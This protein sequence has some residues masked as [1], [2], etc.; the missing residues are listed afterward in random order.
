M[1]WPSAVLLFLAA[2]V[3]L[4]A[5]PGAAAY[6]PAAVAIAASNATSVALLDDGTV[7]QWGYSGAGTYSATPR[8]VAIAGV[9][10]I[11]AGY[12]H[13]LALK[14]DGTV[15]A[16]GDNAYGQ[17]GDG[18]Y[19]ASSEP[20]QASGLRGA[21]AIAAGR[22]V[23]LALTADGTVWAWGSNAYGQTGEGSIDFAGTALPVR[24]E[25][26]EGVAAISAGGSHCMAICTDGTVWAWGDN[27]HGVLGDGT[28]E[29][30]FAPVRSGI[31][32]VGALSAGDM[33]SLS[34]GDTHALAVREDGT[35]WAWGYNYFG[36][37]GTGG[38][39]LND[40]GRY[41]FGT[42][43]DAYSPDLVRGLPAMKSVAAG[44]AHSVALAANGTVWAWGSNADGQLGTGTAGGS[45]VTAPIRVEGLSG[46]IAIDAGLYH[47]LALRNDGS[48][49]AW[50]DS[51]DGQAGIPGASAASPTLVLMPPQVPPS[52]TPTPIVVATPSPSSEAAGGPAYA[53]GIAA[54]ATAAAAYALLS[55]K[56]PPGKSP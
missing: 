51:E 38:T 47:T 45:D 5:V 7:W 16:W 56:R 30:R 1:K 18:T 19:G 12:G 9:R 29:S 3:A 4:A 36:Q 43:A 8:K 6:S 26:L 14:G 54:L 46:I 32:G 23:S 33:H 39:S 53:P 27:R 42:E 17:L 31:Y 37:L 55:K 40:Q 48:V 2:A 15:W 52:P 50:G 28:T 41:Y 21:T 49:W 25:G 24:V 13:V 10:R 35:V 20:V 11:A 34:A 22:D 44:G